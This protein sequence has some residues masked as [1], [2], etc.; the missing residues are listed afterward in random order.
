MITGVDLMELQLR[1][2]RGENLSGLKLPEQ[3]L[4]H[5]IEARICSEDCFN[6][7]LP[8]TGKIQRYE[9]NGKVVNDW[10]HRRG[11]EI[12]KDVINTRLDSNMVSGD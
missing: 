7:F 4:G 9:F 11:N 12:P 6:G 5:S 2:A 10:N 1:V 8:S 3:P